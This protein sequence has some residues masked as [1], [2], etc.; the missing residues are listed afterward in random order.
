MPYEGN[1][2]TVA[3]WVTQ[4]ACISLF[5]AIHNEKLLKEKRKRLKS[6]TPEQYAKLSDSDR[7]IYKQLLEERK[8]ALQQEKA[9][10]VEP[11]VEFVEPAPASKTQ[12]IDDCTQVVF[13]LLLN[14]YCRMVQTN[15]RYKSYVFL[16]VHCNGQYIN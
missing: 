12:V 6:I 7:D 13:T 9:E 1:P 3:E 8:H 2:S 14:L 10:D 15:K 11:V 16:R 4:Q 5:S